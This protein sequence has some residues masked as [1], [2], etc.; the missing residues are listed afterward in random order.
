[1]GAAA[2]E[3]KGI[4]AL[5]SVQYVNVSPGVEPPV[6]AGAVISAVAGSHNGTGL[7]IVSTGVGLTVI[8]KVFEGPVQLAGPFTRIGVTTIVATMAADPLFTALKDAISP[9]PAGA[10]PIPGSLFVHENKVFPIV[11]VVMK[12]MPVVK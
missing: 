7:V 10:R 4:V 6:T 8:V 3:A 12:V 2:G 5:P 1:M 11:F 9:L